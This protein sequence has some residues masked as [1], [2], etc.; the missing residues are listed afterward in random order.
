MQTGG[1]RNSILIPRNS[2][3]PI[4]HRKTYGTIRDNQSFVRV[5]VLEGESEDPEVCAVIGECVVSPLPPDLPKGAPITV[6]FTY[7]NSGRLRVRATDESSGLTAQSTI[8][9]RSTMT[10]ACSPSQNSRGS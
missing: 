8:L 6:T 1:L 5:K 9:R 7:D 3:L 10:K 4:S 2:P